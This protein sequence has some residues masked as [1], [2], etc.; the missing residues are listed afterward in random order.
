MRHFLTFIV[1]FTS[2]F[3]YSQQDS[4]LFSDNLLDTTTFESQLY[5]DSIQEGMLTIKKDIRIDELIREK[6]KIKAPATSLQ[7]DGYRIQLFFDTEKSKVD[8]ARSKFI[9]IHPDIESNVIYKAP[10]YFLKVGNFRTYLEA[11]KIKSTLDKD[12]PTNYILKEKIN[13]PNLD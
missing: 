6:A 11:E 12:F 8:E 5:N 7:I 1:G 2:T 13:I 3:L 4:I 9:E 10:N